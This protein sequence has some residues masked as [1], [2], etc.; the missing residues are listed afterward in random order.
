MSVAGAAVDLVQVQPTR[1]VMWP[2]Q[3]A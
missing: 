3:N 1:S 2:F